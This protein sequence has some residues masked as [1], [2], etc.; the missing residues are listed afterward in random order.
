MN[1]NN[2][3]FKE[4]YNNLQIGDI[5][6][7]K[8]YS[9]EEEKFEYPEGHE[10]GPYIVVGNNDDSLKC[11]YVTSVP[12]KANFNYRTLL[13]NN[14][15]YSLHKVSY[16]SVARISSISK[17]RFIK[18]L[19][20]LTSEDI[21]KLFKK[22]DIVNKEGLYVDTEINVPI[23]PLEPGDIINVG[24]SLYL[25]IDI[26]KD[27][28][29][30]LKMMKNGYKLDCFIMVDGEK[31]YLDIDNAKK[32]KDL[33]KVD[34][35]DYIDNDALKKVLVVFKQRYEYLKHKLEISR[36]SLI[37]INN[38]LYYIYGEIGDTWLAFSVIGTQNKNLYHLEINKKHFYTNFNDNVE[39]SKRHEKIEVIT[40][41]TEKEMEI[42]TEIR[43][44]HLKTLK[45]DNKNK[46]IKPKHAITKKEIQS[47]TIV[48]FK[49]T[50]TQYLQLVILRQNDEII[51]V[52]YD[53]YLEGEWVLNKYFVEQMEVFSKLKN[54][55]LKQALIQLQAFCHGYI[56]KKKLQKNIFELENKESD[57]L[58]KQK[59]LN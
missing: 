35:Y 53:K 56:N 50:N 28:F 34:R 29:Q 31:Y 24:D 8:R 14:I 45:K 32:F 43:K 11:L 12:P 42:I 40:K 13:L 17:D 16:V 3:E 59:T 6:W 37:R 15:N 47:G 25:I 52:Q 33:S 18:K 19:S 22:I 30:C 20:Y 44:K 55:D 41:A 23:I 9:D 21:N 58:E 57:M 4:D 7:A 5:I 36:G 54:F 10:E 39:I 38:A 46:T 27:K 49:N 48:K 26:I 2:N 51:T 1:L